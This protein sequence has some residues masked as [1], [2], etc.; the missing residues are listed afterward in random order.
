MLALSVSV[1]VYVL[2]RSFTSLCFSDLMWLFF[3]HRFI[4]ISLLLYKPY[5]LLDIWL[6]ISPLLV[7]ITSSTMC[8]LVR[9]KGSICRRCELPKSNSSRYQ[10]KAHRLT[11][12][13]VHPAQAPLQRMMLDMNVLFTRWDL[14]SAVHEQLYEFRLKER[15]RPCQVQGQGHECC[16]GR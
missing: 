6:T 5:F 16:H 15:W 14:G 2:S 11:T 1:Y 7:C 8:L 4:L 3:L 9:S 12:P 13:P 10:C